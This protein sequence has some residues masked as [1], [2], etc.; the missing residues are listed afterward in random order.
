M[1]YG[2]KD[3]PVDEHFTVADG[4]KFTCYVKGDD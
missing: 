2:V 4:G 1:I 3:Q